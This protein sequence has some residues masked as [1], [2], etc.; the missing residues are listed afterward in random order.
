MALEKTAIEATL[1]N[2][3]PLHLSIRGRFKIS[4]RGT[5]TSSLQNS[6]ENQCCRYY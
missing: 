4:V 3:Q 2:P 1:E 5:L 6:G